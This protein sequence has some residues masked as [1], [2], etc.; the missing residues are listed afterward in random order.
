VSIC[1]YLT[2]GPVRDFDFPAA[3]QGTEGNRDPAAREH[4]TTQG[5]TFHLQ[6]RGILFVTI[7]PCFSPAYLVFETALDGSFP[8]LPLSLLR[9]P[10][11]GETR[12]AGV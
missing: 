1:P 8:Q 3:E 9:L 10:V 11:P 5:N 2:Q 12:P 6:F 7:F 4:A